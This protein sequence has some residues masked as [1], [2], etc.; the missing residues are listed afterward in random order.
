M[1]MH[2]VGYRVAGVALVLVLSLLSGCV[3][4][5]GGPGAGKVPALDTSDLV[6]PG[7]AAAGSVSEGAFQVSEYAPAGSAAWENIEGGVWLLFS[8]PV[9][10]L[11][12]LGRPAAESDALRIYPPVEGI[13]RWYGSRLL[14]FQPTTS[15][16]PATE[17][18]VALNPGLTSLAGTALEGMNAF[19]FRTPALQLLSLQPSGS[20][21][22]PEECRELSLYFNF[23]VK[24]DTISRFFKVEAA[25]R[26]YPFVALY[27]QE[28]DEESTGAELPSAG[29]VRRDSGRGIV[30]KMQEE[31]PW[32]S[33]VVVRLLEGARP[34]EQNYGT[35]SEQRLGFRTL[36][37]FR[38]EHGEVYDWLPA[39][40]AGLI[41]N[42]PVADQHLASFLDVQLPGY[43][44]EGNV[45]VYGNAVYLKN[46]PV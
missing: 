16:V 37:P 40:E 20:D 19:R 46:L 8:E 13:Y 45:E 21:I 35:E 11:G 28:G 15:L 31:L 4:E 18:T 7:E 29:T 17:Y 43:Q 26:S 1:S 38:L 12:R 9:V 41:F 24:L 39:I 6:F 36:E 5:I 30:L 23:P 10:P 32:D 14:S 3:G 34:G 22:P 33:E 44:L 25:G 27:A 42:H 2:A